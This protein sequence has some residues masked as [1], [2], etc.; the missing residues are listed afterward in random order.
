MTMSAKATPDAPLANGQW[1][2]PTPG[3]LIKIRVTSDETA[4]IYM[5]FEAVADPLNGVPMHVH[6]NEDEH[7]LVLE[8][9]LHVANGN[10]KLDIPAGAAVT[11]KKGVPHAWANLGEIP[12]HFLII[13][14]PGHIEEM[15]MEIA[16]A[17]GDV[18]LSSAAS[19]RFGTALVGPTLADGVY[20]FVSPRP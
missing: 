16:A 17:E 8:G 10:E 12:V 9:T 20:S 1:W 4:G 11:V 14:S 13:F 18:V 2:V 6:A 15:F 3:E 5:M 7:F 19:D